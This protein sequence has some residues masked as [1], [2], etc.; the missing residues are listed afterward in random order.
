[1]RAHEPLR[2][3]LDMAGGTAVRQD[4]LFALHR[5][6]PESSRKTWYVDWMLVNG[7]VC[8]MAISEGHQ[9]Y[10]DKIMR[11][12]DARTWMKEN[13]EISK[14]ASY[15]CNEEEGMKSL[16][17]LRPMVAP[18]LD[19]TSE[20]DLLV[21]CLT[22][23]LHGMPIHA[24]L[25]EDFD[26]HKAPSGY[27]VL[28]ERNPIVY[29]FSMTTFHQCTTR[30]INSA[31]LERRAVNPGVV[32]SVYEDNDQGQPLHPQDP[33]RLEVYRLST[34]I[35]RQNHW[36]LPKCGHIVT[37]ENF[38][39]ACDANI[40]HF[41]GHFMSA[42]QTTSQNV[43]GSGLLLGRGDGVAQDNSGNGPINNIDSTKPDSQGNTRVFSVEDIFDQSFQV[44]TSH[45]TL[46]ACRSASS[47]TT[48]GYESLGFVAA[49][50]CRGANS[51]LA[52]QWKIASVSGRVFT[53]QFY[54]AFR[55]ED[56]TKP[57]DLAL[58]LQRAVKHIRTGADGLHAPYFWAGF[59]L[60]G[61]WHYQ[62]Q[63][64]RDDSGTGSE[65]V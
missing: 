22:E 21:F 33:E 3:L 38:S 61:T 9:A 44:P 62:S 49:L 65:G 64:L 48:Q 4:Q 63:P 1:M 36:P 14:N 24:A 31:S 35:S 8:I 60:Y 37:R 54:K 11:L 55:D 29:T 39:A 10:F 23:P 19:W 18:L 30:S 12:Q 46:I 27:K 5:L 40:V 26:E 50:L 52:T 58:A 34:D 45:F 2:E 32:L 53:E 20:D 57:I 51:V 13:M 41:S 15:L 42:A 56:K 47:Y 59:A 25:I 16:A 6:T 28:I 7:L 17:G 43:L